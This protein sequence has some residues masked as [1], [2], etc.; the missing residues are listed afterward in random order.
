MVGFWGW[1]FDTN[2]RGFL[3]LIFFFFFVVVVVV[4]VGGGGGGG[5]DGCE[6]EGMFCFE[7]KGSLVF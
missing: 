7:M 1:S 5:G 4:V 6:W 3:W 2:C